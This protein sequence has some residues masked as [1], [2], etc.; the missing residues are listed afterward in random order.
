MSATRATC[1]HF[2]IRYVLDDSEP[3][4]AQQDGIDDRGRQYRDVPMKPMQTFAYAETIGS[5]FASRVVEASC[6]DC[7]EN[8]IGELPCQEVP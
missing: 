8:I 1:K 5:N 4:H 2:W 3:S 7:G 6:R